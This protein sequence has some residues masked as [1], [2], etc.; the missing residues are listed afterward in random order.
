MNDFAV[1]GAVAGTGAALVTLAKFWMDLGETKI[2]AKSADEKSEQTA[3]DLA[4]FKSV[5]AEK[6]AS[7]QALASSETRLTSAIEGMRQD[8]RGMTERL[9]RLLIM[10][11]SKATP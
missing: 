4:D 11:Q 2:Q 1:W 6:Y 3:R 9:D 5:V 10:V 8:F 7:V